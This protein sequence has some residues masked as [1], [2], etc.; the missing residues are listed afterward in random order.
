M[1]STKQMSYY[2]ELWTSMGGDEFGFID[3]FGSKQEQNEKI[4]IGFHEKFI[5]KL[6]MPEHREIIRHF[7]ITACENNPN[8]TMQVIHVPISNEN[9]EAIEN[10]V[11]NVKDKRPKDE[12]KDDHQDV[13]ADIIMIDV[14]AHLN[15]SPSAGDMV[16]SCY[17]ERLLYSAEPVAGHADSAVDNAPVQES[18]DHCPIQ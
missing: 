11:N 3:T 4:V 18:N 1:T 2:S 5:R 12:H 14:Y 6:K 16:S 17:M 10:N 7:F 13:L 8:A 15:D 9:N